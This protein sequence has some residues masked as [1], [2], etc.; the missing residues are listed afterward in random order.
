MKI[1]PRTA[2]VNLLGPTRLLNELKKEDIRLVLNGEGDSVD[3]RLELPPAF[4]GKVLLLSTKPAKFR[5]TK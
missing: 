2:T 4:S 1:V 3:A 5:Q